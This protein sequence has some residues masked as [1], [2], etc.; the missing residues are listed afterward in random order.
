[1]LAVGLGRLHLA[2]QVFWSLSLPEWRA[3]T[4]PRRAPALARRDLDLLMQSFPDLP[5]AQ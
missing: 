1:V 2:P 5:H 4:T 3:L